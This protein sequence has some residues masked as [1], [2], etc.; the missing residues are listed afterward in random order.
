ML[1]SV[2][3]TV[4]ASFIIFL[5]TR[6]IVYGAKF[7]SHDSDLQFFYNRVSILQPYFSERP[8]KLSH[9]APTYEEDPRRS[10]DEL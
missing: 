1:V 7:S 8:Y 3:R 5:Q 2:Q 6:M 9:Q 10:D 4:Q